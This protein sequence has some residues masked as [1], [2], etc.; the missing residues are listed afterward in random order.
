MDADAAVSTSPSDSIDS[1]VASPGDSPTVSPVSTGDSCTVDDSA[2]A[3][4]KMRDRSV[5]EGVLNKPNYSPNDGPLKSILKKPK[6]GARSP[7]F[8]GGLKRSPAV[9]RLL[10][11]RSMSESHERDRENE[12]DD[13][14][15]S[16]LNGLCLNSE[17][18]SPR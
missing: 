6:F 1:G 2:F 11:S 15:S 16:I 4:L 12:D 17:R 8:N 3:E 7:S 5:S 9:P 13:A 14:F 18:S 10:F